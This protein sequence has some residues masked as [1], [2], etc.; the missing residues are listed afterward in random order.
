MPP[1]HKLNPL[2]T[3]EFMAS[4]HRAYDQT[5]EPMWSIAARH[6]IAERT[7]QHI[8]RREGWRKRRERVREFVPAQHLLDEAEAM[9]AAVPQPPAPPAV[10]GGVPSPQ[11]ASGDGL[12]AADRIERLVL[13]E[14]EIEETRRAKLDSLPRPTAEAAR[15]ARTL[16]ILTQTLHA[17][18]RLRPAAEAA[19]PQPVDPTHDDDPPR[20]IDEFRRELA[21]RIDAFVAS[22]TDGD[23]AGRGG[24]PR[25]VDE[26]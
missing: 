18:R 14:I 1:P 26:T 15:T 5:N 22:R 21:R 16:A 4:L 2:Y 19:P 10:A 25:L 17:L 13:K 6:G 8:V 23:P 11:A 7:L 20:D 9:L 12:S 24:E 3:P